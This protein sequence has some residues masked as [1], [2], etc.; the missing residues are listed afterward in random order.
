MNLYLRLLFLL[1]T[2][3]FRPRI[4]VSS[5]CRTVFR[6]L[7]TDLDIYGH[8]NNARYLAILDLARLDMLLQSRKLGV[9]LKRGWYPV[10]AAETIRFR[11]SLKIFQR[12]EVETKSLGRDERTVFVQQKVYREG[13]L[14][15]EATIRLSIQCWSAG[16]VSPSEVIEALGTEPTPPVLPAWVVSWITIPTASNGYATPIPYAAD[17]REVAGKRI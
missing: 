16:T 10:V 9:F 3:P 6:C 5:P 12:F 15:A 2:S 14:V 17:A 11:T 1:L 7:P 8:M 4:N 13:K